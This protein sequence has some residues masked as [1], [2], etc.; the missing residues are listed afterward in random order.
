MKTRWWST[1]SLI[2]RSL[3]LKEPLQSHIQNEFCHHEGPNI[4]TQLEKLQLIN[5]D[6]QQLENM[7]FVLNPSQEAQKALEGE[8]YVNLSLLPL[9][10][11]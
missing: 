7:E 9:V 4:Q 10:I 8:N 2:T 11:S 3:E 1:H 6:F 5:S